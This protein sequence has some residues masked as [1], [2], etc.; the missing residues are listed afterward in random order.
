MYLALVYFPQIDH[1][2]FHEFRNTYEPYAALLRE[3]MTFMFP[4]PES[5]GREE[6]E[7]HISEVLSHRDPFKV[8]FCLLEKTVDHWLFWTLEEGM[9]LAVGLHDELYS[10][11]L[12]PHLKT[13]LPFIPHIGLGL[14][15]TEN[16]DFNDPYA[17][18]T[19]DQGRYE[20]ARK[21]FEALNM[22][23]WC[24]IDHLALLR[25]NEEYT[26]C[27]ELRRFSL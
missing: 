11:I 21:E 2:G 1:E 10:G 26:E 18:L 22:D 7:K 14:F 24:T 15:S 17:E 8:H 16:Y 12:S 20:R 9:K 3:H 19:L 5:I 6:L 25:I 4:V 27:T 23:L 13:D